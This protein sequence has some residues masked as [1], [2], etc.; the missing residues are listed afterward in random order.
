MAA[1][2]FKL[3]LNTGI[4]TGWGVMNRWQ[5][6]TEKLRIFLLTGCHKTLDCSAWSKMIRR[7]AVQIYHCKQSSPWL[8]CCLEDRD[9]QHA[10]K[11]TQIDVLFSSPFVL[12]ES[13]AQEV[14]GTNRQFGKCRR[15]WPETWRADSFKKKEKLSYDNIHN[16]TEK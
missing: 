1:I 12:S 14:R 9:A 3:S 15:T 2:H 4:M 7:L 6:N 5:T 8:K 11:A 10:Q 13:T 16:N